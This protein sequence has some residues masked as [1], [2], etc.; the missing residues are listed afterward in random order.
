M[1]HYP[2]FDPIAVSIGPIK[3]HW[4]GLMYLIGFAAA[5]FL[6][7][8]R[9]QRADSPVKPEEVSDLIFWSAIGVILGGRL[10]YGLIYNFDFWLQHPLWIFKVWTGGMSF[11][12]G[13][14]GV[15]TAMWLF[16][17]KIDQPFFALADFVAPLVPIGLAAGRIGNFINGELWGRVTNVPWAMVF[18]RADNLPRHP[19]QLYEIALEGVTLFIVLWFYSAKPRPRMAVSALFLI[20]YGCFR[21]FVEFF[22]QPDAQLGFIA[23]RWLTMGQLLSAPMVVIG[24]AMLWWAHRH[25]VMNRGRDGAMVKDNVR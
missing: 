14:I 15:I 22:R 13:L 16:C 1:L 4:Y 8:G 11:H 9:A 25:P 2:Q 21:F 3:V 20:G 12:G 10:G 19:S 6:A 24:L 17:R 5:W 23:F 18:P 7:L